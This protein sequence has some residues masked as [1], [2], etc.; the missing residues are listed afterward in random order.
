M[1]EGQVLI[2][3]NGCSACHGTNGEGGMAPSWR[4][5]YMQQ[6][7][8][9]DDSK[10]LVD[11]EY[12]K[13]SIKDPTAQQVKGYSIMPPNSLTDAQIQLVIDYIKTLS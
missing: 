12:L 10:V 2:I 5:I 9:D 13:R 6:I 1:S 7:V 4:G 8:L 11:D 3:S